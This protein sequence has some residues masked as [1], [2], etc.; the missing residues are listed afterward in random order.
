M[1]VAGV[2]EAVGQKVSQY[3]PGDEVFG[4]LSK[5]RWGGFAE[6]VCVPEDAPMVAK[7]SDISFDEAAAVPT[8]A[9]TALQGLRDKG[10][11]QPGH[12]V[13]ING[14]SGGVGSSA[15]Q[16]AKYFGAEVTGVCSTGKMDLVGSIGADQVIDYTQEDF[17]KG[18]HSYDVIFDAAAFRSIFAPYL[19]AGGCWLPRGHTFW[20]EAPP[21]GFSSDAPWTVAVPSWQNKNWRSSDETQQSGPAFYKWAAGGRESQTGH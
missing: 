20:R 2:V 6:Y 17:T 7:P 5:Y 8:S 14:A 9:V 12:K 11:I 1:D 21:A 3:Q 16:L 4:D 18:R 19:R 10:H 15:V 13:L